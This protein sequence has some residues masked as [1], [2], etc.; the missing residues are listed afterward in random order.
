MS[1]EL[2]IKNGRAEM[3]Y[4]GD[5][6]W[7]G[8][9]QALEA[10]ASI[11]DWQKSAGMDWTIKR[12]LVRY[13]TERNE[14]GE[15]TGILTMPEKH[16]LF[17]SDTKDALG[18]VSPK[19][20]IVQPP[21]VLEFFR[22]LVNDAGFELNTAG[23]LFGGKRFWALARVA[24]DA[25]IVGQDNV[26][27]F[28]LLSTSAD[29]SLATTARF[30]TVRVVCNNTLGMALRAGAADVSISH[31]QAFDHGLVKDKLGIARGAF[32]EFLG[33]ARELA[34]KP[35]THDQAEALTGCLLTGAEVHT[36]PELTIDEKVRNSHNFKRIMGLFDGAGRGATLPGVQGTAWGWLNA[37]TENV[38]HFAKANSVDHRL[39]N[40]WF[41]KGDETKTE[42][43]ELALNF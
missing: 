10:G 8:L 36:P 25:P 17:R 42:A 27:G 1:H 3:A 7:H 29:G 21:E 2:T 22:D 20:Q 18:L 39:N 37:V 40:A 41:G 34:A 26:G 28:L 31:K 43:F 32:S 11:E 13:A 4:V 12:S 24:P 35:V 9:G 15:S 16:V 38:D 23:T 19:Y 30:T 33:A 14:D 5:T 6:P